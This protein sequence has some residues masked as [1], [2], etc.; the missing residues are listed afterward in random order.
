MERHLV[1]LKE[2]PTAKLLDLLMET[3]KGSMWD[4]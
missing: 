3:K 4:L 1:R 2:N